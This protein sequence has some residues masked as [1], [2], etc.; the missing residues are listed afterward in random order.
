MRHFIVLS[1][2]VCAGTSAFA[3]TGLIT[4]VAGTGLRGSAGINGPATQAQLFDPYCVALDSSGNLYIADSSNHRVV[5]VEAASGNLTLVAGDGT[6]SYSGDGGLATAAAIGYPYCVALDASGSLYISDNAN[7]VV[8]KVDAVARTISTVAGGG[9]G[10]DGGTALGARLFGPAGIAVDSQGNL[11]IT[12]LS[13][14]RVRRVCAAT[15]LINSV[16]GN[17]TSA[18][19]GDGGPATAASMRYPVTV[20]V[21][22]SGN[23]Y[24]SD[25]QDSRVRRVDAVSGNISSVAGLGGP[26]FSGD[27]GPATAAG[28]TYPGSI[29]VDSGGNLFV[30]D[31]NRIRRIDAATGVISTVAGIG[32]EFASGQDGIPATSAALFRA[33]GLALHPSGNLFVSEQLGARVRRVFLPGNTHTYTATTL[34]TNNPDINTGQSATVTA[35]VAPI[36]GAGL[37]AAMVRF[38]SVSSVGP[39]ADLGSAPLVNGSASVTISNQTEG[40]FT[41]TAAYLGDAAFW[42]SS[43]PGIFLRVHRATTTSIASSDNP[44]NPGQ[45]VTFT[46]TVANAADPIPY[47]PA[48]SVQLLQ[49]ATVLAT[50]TVTNGTATLP[51]T[52]SAGGSN[53]LTAAFNSNGG[54]G[55]YGSSTSAPFT[56]TVKRPTTIALVIQPSP[57]VPAQ[58]VTMTATVSPAS[59]TGT[60]HFYDGSTLLG[61]ATL[62]GGVGTISVPLTAGSHTILVDYSGDSV[63]ANSSTGVIQVVKPAT[64][65][66][67]T[68]DINPQNLGNAV[69]FTVQVSPASATGSIQFYDGGQNFNGKLLSGGTVILTVEFITGGDHPITAVYSGDAMYSGST[70]NV[71]TET[72][73]KLVPSL[74]LDASPNPSIFGQSVTMTAAVHAN[75]GGTMQFI[76][77]GTTLGTVSAAPSGVAVYS[78]TSLS[79]GAHTLSVSY[80]G[81]PRYLPAVATA[82]SQQI[83]KSATVTTLAVNPNPGVRNKA[84]VFT[85]TV[86]PAAATGQ[87]QFLDGTTL[88][89]TASLSGGNAS[90]SFSKLG[91][92]THS[93]TASYVGNANF[94]PSTSAVVSESINQH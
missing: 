65:T 62:S 91:L 44:S 56:Q 93:I 63:F 27:G 46:I 75:A 2:F 6:N 74:T 35:T 12:E 37:P 21:D 33:A 61:T 83:V 25:F 29:V 94:G 87:V 22:P 7:N 32:D 15:G 30:T 3:D 40:S 51:V 82:P 41:I 54:I 28:L 18:Y 43:S 34:S 20:T 53:V 24:I 26:A 86:S 77:N 4:T 17:G 49:G 67:I 8:R 52:F 70:S 89:G 58:T 45:T 79:L 59:A 13:G 38:W 19:S 84:V 16:A 11:F 57:S 39:V 5:R 80:S 14:Y 47:A 73:I 88:L 42:S 92:G 31:N 48:G 66:T 23:L 68:V 64:T 90:F 69:T 76:D 60:A 10:G 1:L 55:D 9:F 36:G 85:A 50:G 71:L 78:T 72:I 81:D